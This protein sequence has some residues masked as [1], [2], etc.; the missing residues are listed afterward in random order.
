MIDGGVSRRAVMAGL[1]AGLVAAP[2]WPV[3][4][5]GPAADAGIDALVQAF[6]TRFEV[7]GIAI[8]LIRPGQPDYLKGY[9]VRTL[10]QSAPVDTATLFAIASNS[11]LFTA[12]SLAMLVDEGRLGWDEPVTRYLPDFQMYD[13]AVTRMMT[14]RDLLVHRS[15]LG[16]GQGDLMI[17]PETTHSRADI[18]RGLRY[19]KPERGF[20]AGYAYDNILYIVAG[21]LIEKV[22]G[23]SWEDFVI[24]RIFR[25][26]GMAGAVPTRSRIAS[27]NRAGRHARLG[28]PLRGMGPLRTVEPDDQDKLAAAGGINAGVADIAPWL[29]LLLDGGVLRN[30]ERLWSE[31]QNRELVTPQIIMSNGA[32][33]KPEEP[34]RPVMSGY[35]LGLRVQDYRGRRLLHHSGGLSGQITQQALLPDQGIAIAVYTNTEDGLPVLGL[36]N[37]LLDRLLGVDGLDWVAET[38]RRSDTSHAEAMATLGGGLTRP[39]GAPSLDLAAYAGRYRDPWYGD[40]VVERKGRGLAIAFLPTPAFK[41]PLE[42]WGPDAFRTRFPDGVGEDALVQFVVEKG[43]VS[44]VTMKALSPLADFSFDYQH[45]D[46]APVR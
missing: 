22:A 12:A 10:G 36:R 17:F 11:K 18:L 8:A 13:P 45:L 3:G 43:A 46:F 37:A 32:T 44:R 7:P 26:V 31:A 41:G 24:G 42:P 6:M 27:A 21:L 19:L 1:A 2:L 29:H 9:G 5:A 4:A 20:R 35:A 40:I 28:P 38:Q 33:P 14:V 34:D 16:L 39:A 25:P 15:G 30:G 23:T